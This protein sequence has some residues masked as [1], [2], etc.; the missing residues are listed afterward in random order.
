MVANSFF[1]I[2]FDTALI[3]GKLSSLVI[4]EMKWEQHAQDECGRIIAEL[5][6]ERERERTEETER[7]GEL[8]W[9]QQCTR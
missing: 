9:E 8:N 7:E 6:H 2:L 4:V 3:P 5:Q 1:L